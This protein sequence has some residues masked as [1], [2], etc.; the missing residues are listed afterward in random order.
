ME[1]KFYVLVSDSENEYGHKVTV[2]DLAYAVKKEAQAE[3]A[4]TYQDFIKE[5]DRGDVGF[6]EEYDVRLTEMK[7][8]YKWRVTSAKYPQFYEEMRLEQVTVTI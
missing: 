8:F 2:H 5:C 1:H 4:C 7:D 3:L 6:F